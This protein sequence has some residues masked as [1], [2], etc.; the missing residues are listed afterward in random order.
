VIPAE[1]VDAVIDRCEESER[2]ESRVL[3]LIAEGASARD[4]TAA[5]PADQW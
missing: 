4:V 3:S 2:A 5:L 1:D